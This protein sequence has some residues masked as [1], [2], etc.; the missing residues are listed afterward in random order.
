MKKDEIFTFTTPNGV[1]V[2][3]VVIETVFKGTVEQ[4]DICYAQNRLFTLKENK[5]RIQHGWETTL[6]YDKIIVNYCILPDYDDV[7]RKHLHHERSIKEIQGFGYTKSEA[8][9]ILEGKN[10]DGSNFEELPF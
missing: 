10:A 9:N 1:E 2:A 7:L 4:L 8:L 6:E 5:T 3:A